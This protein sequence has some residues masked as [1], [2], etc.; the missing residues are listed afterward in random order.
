M[1]VDASIIGAGASPSRVVPALELITVVGLLE[2]ELWV[3]RARR[4][5]GS[6][7]SRS[8]R[9]GWS[10]GSPSSVVEDQGRACRRLGRLPVVV[11]GPRDLRGRISAIM[12]ISA[13]F[14][15][16][17][18][19]T[20]E[21]LFL[22]KPP[23]KLLNWLIG[24][25]GAALGQQLA[26][27]FFL[28]PVC[29]EL[30]RGRASGMVLAASIFGLIHL[31][32]PTLVAI[33]TLGG[34]SWIVLYRRSGRLAPL[35]ASH[36]ILATLAHGTLPERLTYDM[37]VGHSRSRRSPA[38]RRASPTPRPGSSTVVSRRTGRA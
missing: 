1:E 15:G 27:Q 19:E 5:P 22:S 36:M 3:L 17:W 20:F 30:T 4:R 37:R 26:L 13:R 18:N 6:T 16:D 10:S 25:F 14:V 8:G 33:T 24:K 31:P 12:M 28:A 29:V 2:A 38:V 11:R 34:L 7:S 32:S 23:L 9:S 35:V 21:F